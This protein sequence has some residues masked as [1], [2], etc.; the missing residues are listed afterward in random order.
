M[1]PGEVIL[2]RPCDIDTSGDIWIYEPFD[3]K[4]R[5]RGIRK[6]IPLGPE[7]QKIPKPFL[8]REAGAFL[9]SPRESEAWRLENRP[10]YHGRQRTTPLYASEAK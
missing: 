5:W 3:H 6:Q 4:G 10:P 9:F 1:R 8:D 7:A 2:M